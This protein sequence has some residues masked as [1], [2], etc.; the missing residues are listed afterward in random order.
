MLNGVY[1]ESDAP[2]APLSPGTDGYGRRGSQ[3]E[4]PVP[5]E[6]GE[7]TEHAVMPTVHGEREDRPFKGGKAAHEE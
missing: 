6:S 7:Q 4:P 1:Q 3:S 5:G 2:P